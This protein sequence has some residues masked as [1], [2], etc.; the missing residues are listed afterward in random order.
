MS[1]LSF[2]DEAASGAGGPRER[3]ASK[4]TVKAD[5]R[6]DLSIWLS[7]GGRLDSLVRAC[8]DTIP[9]DCDHYC[10]FRNHGYHNGRGTAFPPVEARC[11][12]C[13]FENL[14]LFGV[15]SQLPVKPILVHCIHFISAAC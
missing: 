14:S 15:A 8:V 9:S 1:D 2:R 6:V 11:A 13:V 4:S 10:N 3:S 12:Q 5:A 7:L